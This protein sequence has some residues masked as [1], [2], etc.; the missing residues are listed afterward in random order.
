MRYMIFILML[1]PLPVFALS[2]TPHS[3]SSVYTQAANAK[4][5]Y[6]PVHGKLDFDLSHLPQ[7]D[8]EN[9]QATPNRTLIPATFKGTALR[10]RGKPVPFETEVTLEVRCAGPWCPTP[11]PGDS[12]G[13][14]RETAEGYVLSTNA[15]GGFLFARP[16]KG[17]VKELQDCLAGRHCDGIVRR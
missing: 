1:L 5:A 6:L 12:L 14:L 4:E 11:Q 3:I 10:A 7:T 13:F 16:S 2:C 9:Q 8:W 17:Q 15:C